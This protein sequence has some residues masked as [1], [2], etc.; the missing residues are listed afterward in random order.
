MSNGLVVKYEIKYPNKS[1]DSILKFVNKHPLK[2]KKIVSST[3]L[4]GISIKVNKI[5]TKI[6]L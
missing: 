5:P 6:T 3:H 2:I 1:G 4:H